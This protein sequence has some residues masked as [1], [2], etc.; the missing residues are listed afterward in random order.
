MISVGPAAGGGGGYLGHQPGPSISHAHQDGPGLLP[1]AAP[2]PGSA[3]KR[4]AAREH[5]GAA[6]TP[7]LP[8]FPHIPE[9]VLKCALRDPRAC[10]AILMRAWSSAQRDLESFP[11]GADESASGITE[12]SSSLEVHQTGPCAETTSQAAGGHS[13][14]KADARHSATTLA[15]LPTIAAT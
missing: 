12:R 1:D 6:R 7:E 11:P 8:G 10:T 14:R 13:D 4:R 9:H 15:E 5:E 3:A 2:G